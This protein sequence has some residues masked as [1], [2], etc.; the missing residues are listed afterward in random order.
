MQRFINPYNF[1]PLSDTPV[2]RLETEKSYYTG[3]I[4]YHLKTRSRLFI[5]NTSSDKAFSYTPDEKDDPE[6]KHKLYDFFS[7]ETLEEGKVYDK[8]EDC[9]QPVIPGSEV[10]GMLR[11]I[12]ETLTNSCLSVV[13]G[14][15]RISKRTVEHFKPAVLKWENG[16][17]RLYAAKDTIYRNREDFSDKIYSRLNILDGSK[18]FFS[19]SKPKN[20][21]IK[22]DVIEIYDAA[23]E[24][25]STK[26]LITGYLLKGNKGPDIASNNKS[27]CIAG[28][29]KK[30]VMLQ[31]G[32]CV[33]K[34]NKAENCYLAEKHCAH[35]FYIPP[36]EK[37]I[38]VNEDSMDT[39]KVILEHYTKENSASYEEY[40]ISYKN[41]INN[42]TEELPVY[43]SLFNG[44][45]Y[46][47]LSPACIT[48]EVYKN[49]VDTLI[50][51]YKK[52][53]SKE[54]K[55]CPACHLFG[56]V[57]SDVA[58]GSKIRF[59]DLLPVKEFQDRSEYYNAELLTL[60]P[61]VAPHLENTEF[62]L[63]KPARSDKDDN[64]EGEIEVWFWTYDYY[65]VKMPDGQVIVKSN[66]PEISG[67]KFYWNNFTEISNITQKTPFN[68]TVR[69]VRS[70]I[71]FTGTIYFDK[72]SKKQLSQL[73]Y[74]LNYT[75]D[76]K[77]GYKL[78][79]GKPLGLGSV[80]LSVEVP[81]DIFIRIYDEN[82][83]HFLSENEKNE[84]IITD[85]AKLDFDNRVVEAFEMM[86]RY[87]LPNEM[88]AIH[89][90]KNREKDDEKGFEWTEKNR[91]YYKY[92][93]KNHLIDIWTKDMY[94]KFQIQTKLLY[95][96]PSVGQGMLPWLP[97]DPELG[98]G[99]ITGTI[100]FYNAEKNYGYISVKDSP[101]YQINI[102]K[103]NPDVKPED[104]KKGCKVIF[105]PK[106][107]REKLVANQC[108]LL[109]E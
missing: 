25:S 84:I 23:R 21:F 40:M 36:T 69:T 51:D 20:K 68:Q 16:R 90:P 62:Y 54:R 83:Y 17:V 48:K 33:G 9:F 58:Q 82:E 32:L 22:P 67:R 30:C 59:T 80:E 63:K 45:E 26:K 18:V 98:D 11:S 38:L 47:L 46:I 56:I 42:R 104:L 39:L 12:Y 85:I 81:E 34:N 74:I 103:Y 3:S 1:I 27:K 13:D 88:K 4:T 70:G 91:K 73:L 66:Q 35:V 86:T 79:A 102:N 72:I 89:Y 28:E 60:D 87:L 65:T 50:K 106:T 31:K 99:Y 2:R 95:E 108:R 78:G 41:F 15:K 77:H 100:K 19:Y 44:S 53:N 49:T 109:M 43:Y 96:M 10:R 29:N 71:D 5:P 55:L 37:G 75:S 8:K 24:L 7:Y 92:N 94:P 64:I 57:N 61:L 97:L 93:E 6:N 105:I 14:K 76:G 101:D 52:C 107:I